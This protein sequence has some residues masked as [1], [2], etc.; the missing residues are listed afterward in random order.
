[1]FRKTSTI[2]DQKNSFHSQVTAMFQDA[3]CETFAKTA[4]SK[5]VQHNLH[6]SGGLNRDFL[7]KKKGQ[8]QS[9]ALIT[10]YGSSS[11][12]RMRQV[13]AMIFQIPRLCP[14]SRSLA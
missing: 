11:R 4:W 9:S 5:N 10:F 6:Y 14:L 1:M 13:C 2:S 7:G 8:I 12:E 3:F